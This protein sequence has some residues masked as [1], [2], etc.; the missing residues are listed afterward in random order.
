MS[1]E[2]HPAGPWPSDAP[3]S[4]CRWT[5]TSSPAQQARAAPPPPVLVATPV[6]MG[7][8]PLDVG[9]DAIVLHRPL[10]CR[11]QVAAQAGRPRLPAGPP[12]RPPVPRPTRLPPQAGRPRPPAGPPRLPPGPRPTRLPPRPSPG[13]L[14]P[15][16]LLKPKT[17]LFA[18]TTRQRPS[19]RRAQRSDQTPPE[20]LRRPTLAT[21]CD[22]AGSRPWRRV[23]RRWR[24]RSET[25]NKGK[26]DLF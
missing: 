7:A 2:R 3:R 17:I 24:T 6:A 18:C 15:R 22:E 12:R 20:N 5:A 16:R 4:P 8:I 23:Q 10:E 21:S 14:L 25:W 11:V 9:S 19:R 1:A 13:P 26:T